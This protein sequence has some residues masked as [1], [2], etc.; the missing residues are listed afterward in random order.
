MKRYVIIVICFVTGYIG[1]LAELPGWPVETAPSTGAFFSSPIVADFDLDDD[2]EV[3]TAGPDNYVRAFDINGDVLPGF[4]FE[5]SG[6]ISS[7]FALGNVTC[8]FEEIVVLTCNGNLYVLDMVPEPIAPFN[9]LSIGD[10]SGPAGPVLWDFD[11]DGRVEIVVHAGNNIH[12][13]DDDG[14]EMGT[15]PRAV[16]SEYGPAGSPAVGDI[17]AD[18]EAEILAIGYQKLYAFEATGDVLL[19]FPVELDTNE[20]FSYSSPVLVDMDN[21]GI[22]EI[23][24]GYHEI[25]GSSRGKIGLWDSA[26]EMVD[27]WPISAGGYGS[28]IYGSCAVGDIDGDG[29]PEIVVTSLNERGYV[30]NEDATFPDPWSLELGIGAL[31]SSPLLYDFNCDAGPDILFLGSDANGT[32]ACLNAPA[33]D[34]DSF[35]FETDTSYG[36]ATPTAGDFDGDG[37]AEFCAVDRAG[38]MHMF[39][40]VG[41]GR[42]YGKPWVMGRHDP[43]RTGWLYPN[44]PDT[45]VVETIGDS[46]LIKWA[47]IIAY[48]SLSYKLYATEDEYDSS[49][50]TLLV[51]TIDTFATVMPDSELSYYFVTACSRYS[52]SQASEIVTLDTTAILESIRPSNYVLECYPNPFNSVCNIIAP[53]HSTITIYSFDGRIIDEIDSRTGVARWEPAIDCPSGVYLI[54]LTDKGRTFNR[55]IV[56]LR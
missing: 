30:V 45:V 44:T 50:G 11:H 43:L 39:S 4:P 37:N 5:L 53:S 56:L 21:D 38:M 34:I 42:P 24:C 7:Y 31:E 49:G 2:L 25:T 29:K 26:G 46:I 12:V 8:E 55:R 40:Y 19:G 33:A 6:G 48:D 13:F 14:T 28:W 17:D 35:P 36:F 10:S 27:S 51:N 52:E 54:S 3:I 1:G 47:S 32:V 22:L 41:D 20:A 15:F 9:P 23:C 18:G 16:D